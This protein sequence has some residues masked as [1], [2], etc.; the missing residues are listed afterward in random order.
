MHPRSANK[1]I[2]P[3]IYWTPVIA[4][5]TAFIT[6]L[7]NLIELLGKIE[8]IEEPMKE[9]P[10]LLKLLAKFLIYGLSLVIPNIGIIWYFFYLAGISPDR[11]SETEFFWAIVAQPTM[12]VSIYA[13]VW[14]RWIY[15]RL[16][17]I[18]GK[19]KSRQKPK[20]NSRTSSESSE[21]GGKR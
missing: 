20:R 11:L 21:N 17:R 1:M 7:L 3:I 18:L 2:E 5:L 19:S 15:P 12:G 6:L 13:Y 16:Q 4:A 10:Y 8:K 9:P 14:A